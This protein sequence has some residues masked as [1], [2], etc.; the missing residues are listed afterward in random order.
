MQKKIYGVSWQRETKKYQVTTKITG[1]T[2]YI[3]IGITY[4]PDNMF[5]FKINDLTCFYVHW[6]FKIHRKQTEN[7][8][9]ASFY[10]SLSFSSLILNF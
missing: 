9:F 7:F 5:I 1:M 8:V 2:I 6:L 10:N 3:N 4:A